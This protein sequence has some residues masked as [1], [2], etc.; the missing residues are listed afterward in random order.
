MTFEKHEADDNVGGLFGMAEPSFDDAP[1]QAAAKEIITRS[2]APSGIYTR[3]PDELGNLTVLRQ[4]KDFEDERRMIILSGRFR[5]TIK[6]KEHTAFVR[7]VKL[8]PDRRPAKE[9]KDGKPTG[10]F[11]DKDD[12]ASVLWAKAVETYRKTFNELPVS[13]EGIIAFLESGSYKVK[14]RG[15][16]GELYVN[17]ILPLKGR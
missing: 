1:D 3:D 17:E 12:Q 14:I 9:W 16:N 2:L 11:L 7:N 15:Y 8:S 10:N 13:N 6:G 5:A 4:A